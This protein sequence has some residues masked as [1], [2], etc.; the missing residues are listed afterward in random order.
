MT[1]K[2]VP[3]LSGPGGCSARA[4]GAQRTRATRAPT[5]LMLRARRCIGT[6]QTPPGNGAPPMQRRSPRPAVCTLG[7]G[8]WPATR[9]SVACS[10]PQPSSS[11]RPPRCCSVSSKAIA[12]VAARRTIAY[13]SIHELVERVEDDNR[14]AVVT[15]AL[16]RSPRPSGRSSRFHGSARI[17]KARSACLPSFLRPRR[18]SGASG[19][20]DSPAS[21]T[22]LTSAE[23]SPPAEADG[24]RVS[25]RIAVL[26]DTVDVVGLTDNHAGRARRCLARGRTA[27]LP[28]RGGSGH[29]RGR[30]RVSGDTR[31]QL[32]TSKRCE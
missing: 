14:P 13:A 19:C 29:A 28:A 18:V 21:V 6:Y 7:E 17:E 5:A 1:K 25:D 20:D 10:R 8:C 23:I 30:R 9:V 22:A 31:H 3:W 2:S 27:R 32:A 11:G 26:A 12:G 15:R 24:Q 16:H 4:A